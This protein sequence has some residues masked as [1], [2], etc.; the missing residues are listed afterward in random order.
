MDSVH[1]GQNTRL[2]ALAKQVTDLT[3]KVD[4]L[5][6]TGLTPEQITAIA[7]KVADI[8]HDRLAN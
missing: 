5:T 4:S 7:T 8:L 3:A 1:S 6:T 2:D